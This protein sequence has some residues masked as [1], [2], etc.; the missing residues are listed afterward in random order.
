MKDKVYLAAT[1]PSTSLRSGNQVV[2]LT[3]CSSGIGLATA[4]ILLTAGARVFGVDISPCPEILTSSSDFQFMRCDLT[5][6][7]APDEVAKAC[8]EAFGGRI[9]VLL[10]VA[11]MMD[12]HFL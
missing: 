10:N 4:E 3:G 2:I 11:G 1:I 12:V 5:K 9:D 7:S 8:K 6:S